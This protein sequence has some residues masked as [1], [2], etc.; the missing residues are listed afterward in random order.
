MADVELALRNYRARLDQDCPEVTFADVQRRLNQEEAMTLTTD[1]HETMSELDQLDDAVELD[2]R[3]QAEVFPLYRRAPFIGGLVAAAVLLVV[4]LAIVLTG[5]DSEPLITDVPETTIAPTPTTTEAPSTTLEQSAPAVPEVTEGRLAAI[6]AFLGASNSEEWA[7]VTTGDV[8][9]RGHSGF[10]LPDD[11][12]FD[13]RLEADRIIEFEI[14]VMPGSCETA[15]AETIVRCVVTKTDAADRALG[16][17]PF[18]LDLTF[19]FE[20]DL[21]SAN[22]NMPTVNFWFDLRPRAIEAGLGD[23][24]DAV[25]PTNNELTVPCAEFVMANLDDWTADAG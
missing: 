6:E 25:C 16:R 13:A 10:E 24:F 12:A 11:A 7:A 20:G 17:E 14:T 3:P 8:E 18:V 21:I 23:E 19:F 22:P 5:D 9:R 1:D 2:L 15:G 4:A